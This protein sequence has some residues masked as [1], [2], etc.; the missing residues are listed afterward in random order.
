MKKSDF[1]TFDIVFLR[2]NRKYFYFNDLLIST[3]NIDSILELGFYNDGLTRKALYE[4]D[5]D[6]M[7]VIRWD[8]SYNVQHLSD[9]ID[10]ILD[11]NDSEYFAKFKIIFERKETLE[12]TI[13]DIA[14]KYN[15]SP[16]QI[17]IKK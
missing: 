12:L 1:K 7:R 13:D 10:K 14:K 15:V 4:K 5:Y 17:R 16:N 2:N 3:N 9:F 11:S 6:I 8:D